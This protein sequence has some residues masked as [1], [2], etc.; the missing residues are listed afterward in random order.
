MP[1]G[2]STATSLATASAPKLTRTV[3]TY[4]LNDVGLHRID[5]RVLAYNTRA[6][7]CYLRAGFEE[8]GREREA[9]SWTAR[10]TT[11]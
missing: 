6:I 9:L 10:G 1:W 5:L 8:E 11:M 7:G 4:G 3:V 2:S